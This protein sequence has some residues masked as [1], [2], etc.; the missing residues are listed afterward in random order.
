M[1]F[2][3]LDL[4]VEDTWTLAICV[5]DSKDAMSPGLFDQSLTVPNNELLFLVLAIV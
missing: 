1:L 2:T 4:V 5:L 3:L